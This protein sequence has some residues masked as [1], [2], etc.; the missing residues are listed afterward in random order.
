MRVGGGGGL[1]SSQS[2]AGGGRGGGLTTSQ[3]EAGGRGG[4]GGLFWSLLEVTG[5]AICDAIC[6]RN[7]VI[8]II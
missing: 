8:C 2:E 3:S 5:D 1:T 6:C 7:H 4:G